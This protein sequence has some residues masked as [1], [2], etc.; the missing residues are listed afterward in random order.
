MRYNLYCSPKPC[1]TSV[2][3]FSSTKGYLP[4]NSLVSKLLSIQQ[5]ENIPLINL[6]TTILPNEKTLA[7]QSLVTTPHPTSSAPRSTPSQTRPRY[8]Q[9]GLSI[10]QPPPRGTYPVFLRLLHP[11]EFTCTYF[12]I[13]TI[14]R[15]KPLKK[16]YRAINRCRLPPTN[17]WRCFPTRS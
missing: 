2:P 7:Y 6:L 13:T 5:L 12:S 9:P 16:N 3:T 4:S 1:V 14:H 11:D 10:S 17:S 8:L 15:P